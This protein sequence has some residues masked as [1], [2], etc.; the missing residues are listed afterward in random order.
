MGRAERRLMSLV[1]CV[2]AFGALT[3]PASAQTVQSDGR[4]TYDAAYFQTYAPSSALDIV[5]RVP[6]FVL[7]SGDQDVRGF[8]QAAGNLVINGQRP[9][10]KSDS[11]QT[12]LSRIPASRV[13]RVEIGSGDLFG[14]EYSGK[15]QVVNLI[16]S[17][18]DGL[19]GTLDASVRRSFTGRWTPE[20]TVSL[21]Y[22]TGASTFNAALEYD[23]FYQVEE[24]FDRLS[25]IPDNREI[26]F[27]RK[28]NFIRN[29]G[30]LLTGSWAH[31]GGD[32]RT[33]SVNFRA[34]DG[35]FALDQVNDVYP[36]AGPV[37][38]DGLVDRDHARQY[39]LGGDITRPLLGGGIKLLGLA[40]RRSNRA[41]T[42]VFNRIA[43]NVIGGFEQTQRSIRDERI[44]RL[45]WSRSNLAGWSVETGVEGAFNRLD[46]NVDLFAIT[47]DNS[48]SRIDLPVD[49][50]VVRERRGEA[51]VNLGRAL[52]STL[53]LD[54]GLTYET[55]R[56]TVSGDTMAE[57]TLS[58]WKPKATLD[59][60]PGGSWHA[61][62]AVARTVAQLNFG[63][64]VSAAELTSDR[65]N[66]GNAELVPQR[67]WEMLATVERPIL[68]DG[69]AKVELGY[70]RISLVQD[71]VPT[72]EGFDA[73]G[74]LG[75]GTV[76]F[77][78]GSLD[79]PLARLGITGGRLTINGQL[80][81]TSVRDP[82]TG[83]DR[84]FSNFSRWQMEARFRQD[85]GEFAWGVNYF[86]F[87]PNIVFRRDEV[88]RADGV[89]PFIVLF[90]EYRPNR[91]TTFTVSLENL[92]DV[93]FN[94]RRTFFSPDRS[95]PTPSILEYRE[96]ATHSTLIFNFKYNLG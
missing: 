85:L 68:G 43:G 9:S 73:P 67:A 19:A 83:L 58:F 41:G 17:D 27:R 12:I 40:T 95:N 70:Q 66:S 57:R 65:V 79:G 35:R 78:R 32:N 76:R 16:L 88:D 92:A 30:P 96:R 54:T 48:R 93:P 14:S 28:V 46:S 4:T 26:E 1:G 62:F 60:R 94:R 45:V 63:D 44:V 34:A 86:G 18:T 6:G 11:L 3:Q 84:R 7:Q 42:S 71:R 82:Y 37:R 15:P 39:E 56:L 24:G 5:Q 33:I 53:R 36:A 77:V 74:N 50:V 31:N 52:G 89:E 8:G 10:S 22:R 13:L 25:T 55:S 91:R 47:A 90:A 51:F 75:T 81:D 59:W 21:L 38:D 23:N 49:Q 64:F 29:H 2:A 72:P 80:R 61:Q 20:A 87:P 69:L